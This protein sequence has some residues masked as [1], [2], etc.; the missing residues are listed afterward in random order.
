MDK[1]ISPL[2]DAIDK[3]NKLRAPRHLYALKDNPS[4]PYNPWTEA[5]LNQLQELF[6]TATP[7]ELKTK[8]YPHPLQAIYAKAR[9]LGLERKSQRG[10]RY[11][12]RAG[13][14]NIFTTLRDARINANIKQETVAIDCG[15]DTSMLQRYESGREISPNLQKLKRWAKYFGFEVILK[16][17]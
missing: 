17:L 6:A 5:E 16:K 13:L 8:L 4:K 2:M 12:P 15:F 11:K 14:D 7:E 3:H 10:I 9:A 1:P